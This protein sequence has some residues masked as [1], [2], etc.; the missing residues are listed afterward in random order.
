MPEKCKSCRGTGLDP[1]KS[2]FVKV[3]CNDCDG[4]GRVKKHGT[5]FFTR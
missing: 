1:L 4:T 3:S 5:I 2:G